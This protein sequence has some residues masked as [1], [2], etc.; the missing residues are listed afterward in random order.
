M[1][2]RVYIEILRNHMKPST[3][4]LLPHP[5]DPFILQHDND[6]KH[7]SRKTCEWLGRN[8][9]ATLPWPAQ[10]P[11]LNPI[12]HLWATLKRRVNSGPAPAT[13][14]K[15]WER[16]KATW[17]CIDPAECR[18]LVESMPRRIE[19]VIRARGG[20]PLLRT[21]SSLKGISASAH[22]VQLRRYRALLFPME[23]S[24]AS[25]ASAGSASN[26]A[27]TH[28]IQYGYLVSGACDLVDPA[29][30]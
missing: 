22:V 11:D 15:L 24:Q 9:V 25:C 13:V 18:D 10:S 21:A 30:T 28:R 7:R 6:P 4:W 14:D 12:E 16:L 3:A 26:M 8:H 1:D 19:A 27:R 29:V 20:H 17:W 5:R 2:S 23:I